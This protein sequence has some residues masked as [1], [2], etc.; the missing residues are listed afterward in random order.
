MKR[1][2]ELKPKLAYDYILGFDKLFNSG[3]LKSKH[4]GFTGED[5][6][7][8]AARYAFVCIADN[9][10]HETNALKAQIAFANL[11]NNEL[12]KQNDW[13][14]ERIKLLQEEIEFQRK[15]R[16]KQFSNKQP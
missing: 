11:R 10:V 6:V 4:D 5:A 12:Q 16:D 3:L 15:L 1:D 2:S 13:Q 14:A 7:R 8:L 9:V